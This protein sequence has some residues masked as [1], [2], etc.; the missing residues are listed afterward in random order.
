MTKDFL[1][2]FLQNY[3]VPIL[4]IL[5]VLLAIA[6]VYYRLRFVYL[7]YKKRQYLPKISDA[8][9]ELTF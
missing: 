4:M 3:M 1:E 8:L 5:L 2:N 6:L 7:T 9:T